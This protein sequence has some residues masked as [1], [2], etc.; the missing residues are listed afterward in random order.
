MSWINTAYPF[1][2]AWLLAGGGIGPEF[3][4]GTFFFL[5]PYNYLMYGLNDVHD[6]ASDVL[7]PRKGGIEGALVPPRLHRLIQVTAP[8]LALPFVAWLLLAGT[9]LSG[10]VLAASLFAVVAYS[11]PGLRFKERPFL[12]SLTSSFHFVSPA[13]FALALAGVVPAPPGI[14]GLTAFFLWGCA[15][16][17]FGAVQDVLPDRAAGIASVA[18]VLGARRTVLLAILLWTAAGLLMLAAAWPARLAAFLVLPYLLNALPFAGVSDAGSARTNVAWRRFVG[19]NY[20]SGFL[21]TMLLVWHWR[22]A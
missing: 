7:N 9:V 2:A 8:L 20:F 15:A 1:G 10:A 18:T 22:M 12:D 13:L 5:V 16:H 17:A 21:L 11:L 19:L 14:L 6:H 4:L 3:L